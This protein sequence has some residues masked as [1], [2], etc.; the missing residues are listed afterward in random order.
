MIVV[1]STDVQ[2]K[3]VEVA[4]AG[5]AVESAVAE[6][7]LTAQLRGTTVVSVGDLSGSGNTYPSGLAM[8]VTFSSSTNMD[9]V[10]I[11][12]SSA[13]TAIVPDTAFYPTV[14]WDTLPNAN[15]ASVVQDE[16]NNLYA[17]LPGANISTVELNVANDMS[18]LQ[19]TPLLSGLSATTSPTGGFFGLGYLDGSGTAI[20]QAVPIAA[21]NETLDPIAT[22]AQ[23][24]VS[25]QSDQ[26]PPPQISYLTIVVGA[27]FVDPCG[28]CGFPFVYGSLI[29]PEVCV[30][31]VAGDA[32]VTET[33]GATCYVS[34]PSCSC[35]NGDAACWK[36]AILGGPQHAT[37]AS[38]ATGSRAALHA[39]QQEPWT[40][41]ACSQRPGCCHEPG[42]TSPI[43][44]LS[45][46]KLSVGW[47]PR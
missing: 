26:S 7:G 32:C 10:I 43:F 28:A 1:N 9:D 35:D 22:G 47:L 27:A 44:S 17:F 18:T 36:L 30:L 42:P 45:L 15:V 3:T 12:F 20:E 6:H 31:N 40:C 34:A 29:E 21:C 25:I 19:I 46:P 23:T 16:Q 14:A 4:F 33:D 39:H 2:W 8:T 13:A 38:C 5:G 11:D 37:T 24:F 41:A